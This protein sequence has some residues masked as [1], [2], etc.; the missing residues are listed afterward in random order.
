MSSF[1]VALMKGLYPPY[2]IFV[3]LGIASA[4]SARRWR[5]FDTLLLAAFLVFELFAAVQTRLFYGEWQTS[6]R[7]MWIALPL[8]LPFAARGA[9]ALWERLGR[10]VSGRVAALLLGALFAGNA[11]YGTFNPIYRMWHSR[12]KRIDRAV[13]LQAAK[14]IKKDWN[15]ATAP[16]APRAMR[17]DQYQSGK[18][19]LVSSLEWDRTGYLSGGQ[20]YTEFLKWQGERPDYIVTPHR[21]AAFSGYDLAGTVAAEGKAAYIHKRRAGA[22][23]PSGYTAP[24]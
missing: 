11:L 3:V 5:S 16:A 19:P 13:T 1:P 7:Y 10:V 21:S 2:L 8:Y 4:V 24:R 6:R 23:T 14:W 22:E 9:V 15:A 18:R 17:C 12:G 20:A